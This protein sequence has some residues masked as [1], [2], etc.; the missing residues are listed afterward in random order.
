M[1]TYRLTAAA[2]KAFSLNSA[3]KHAYRQLGNAI[4]GRGRAAGIKPGYIER[5]DANLALIERHG[6]I[7]DG[8]TV[9]EL[10]T[11][12]V[13]W[14]ALFTR[15]FYDVEFVLFDVWDNRQF[16]AFR[17]YVNALTEALPRLAPRDPAR[18]ERA[19]RLARQVLA[20]TS[21]EEVYDLLSMR[22]HVDEEGLLDAIADRSIDLAISSDVMEHVPAHAL[23]TLAASLSRVLRSGGHVAQ[24][25]V[26]ADHLCI[27][28]RSAHPK[29][30]L[31]FEDA[32]WS[33]WFENSVQYQNR[34]QQSDFRALFA[35]YGFEIVAD[36]VVATTDTARLRIASRW[37]DY[38]KSDL[39]ATVTRLLARKPKD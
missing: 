25:I 34:W 30:Y 26:P 29:T 35:E 7:A 4:G 27:Y 18:I 32:Q 36:E 23:P 6:A 17:T 8:M 5:A 39:D 31:Q 21:F 33:R 11:G 10:G 37:K 28:A 20:C 3:T 24:Q 15:L 13:H 22:Y 12:W 38:E 16:A 19:G 1:L 9:L 14:E 2:L